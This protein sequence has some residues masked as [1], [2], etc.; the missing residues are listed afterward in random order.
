MVR[1]KKQDASIR[2][3]LTFPQAMWE[4]LQKVAQL[5]GQSASAIVRLAVDEYLQKEK[6]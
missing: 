4:N 2:T 1:P 6:K 3:A 5:K